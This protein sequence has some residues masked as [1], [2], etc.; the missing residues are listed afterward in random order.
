MKQNR[1][2]NGVNETKPEKKK[3]TKQNNNN[4]KRNIA[5]KNE[6]GKRQIVDKAKLEINVAYDNGK[7]IGETTLPMKQNKKK[8]Y[9][10]QT[11][12]QKQAEKY[13]QQKQNR[14]EKT[15]RQNNSGK[16]IGPTKQKRKESLPTTTEQNR[17]KL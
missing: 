16:N 2:G 7:K 17:Q 6:S 1:R 8:N 5:N 13:G 4:N 14:K 9:T 12:Q 11:K 3:T 15:C 10:N